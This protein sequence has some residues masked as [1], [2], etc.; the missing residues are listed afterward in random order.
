VL[1][2]PQVQ[3]DLQAPTGHKDQRE[4]PVLLVLQVPREHPELRETPVQQ[5][6]PGRKALRDLLVRVEGLEA[7]KSFK[8]AALLSC[9]LESAD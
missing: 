1:L 6:R 7:G 4:T 2:A 5:D 9:R 3:P 8:A